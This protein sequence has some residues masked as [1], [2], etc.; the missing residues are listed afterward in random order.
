MAATI[1][2][3]F[4]SESMRSTPSGGFYIWSTL[5]KYINTTDLLAEAINNKVAFVPGK[6]FYSDDRGK[7]EMRLA[8]CTAEPDEIMKGIKRLANI[9]KDQM[10]LYSLL[11][12]KDQK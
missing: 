2:N 12:P 9:I 4:P 11:N 3:L 5:P 7:N 10:K 6:A 1:D 8:F